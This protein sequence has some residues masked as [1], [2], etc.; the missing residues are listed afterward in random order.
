MIIELLRAFVYDQFS[1]DQEDLH[2]E[3]HHQYLVPVQDVYIELSVVNISMQWSGRIS[4]MNRTYIELSAGAK[5]TQM[6]LF[7][8][9]PSLPVSQS[10][11]RPALPDSDVFV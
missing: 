6:C 10:P 7:S 8:Y 9:Q 3:P 5:V 2:H 11:S 1:G 4:D